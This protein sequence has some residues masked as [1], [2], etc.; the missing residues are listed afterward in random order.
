[1]LQPL[2]V[3]EP[4]PSRSALS[5]TTTRER[6]VALAEKPG[7]LVV[8]GHLAPLVQVSLSRFAMGHPT[9]RRAPAGLTWISPAASIVAYWWAAREGASATIG[10][11][12]EVLV[13]DDHVDL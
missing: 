2:L 1:M 5:A 11:A 9:G 6:L 10:V 12:I 8:R 7:N 4:T 13:P 3:L